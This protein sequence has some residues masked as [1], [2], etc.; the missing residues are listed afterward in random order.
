MGIIDSRGFWQECFLVDL[1]FRATSVL[2]HKW[3]MA[4]SLRQ[5][6]NWFLFR[7]LKK[8]GHKFEI[9][10][11]KHRSF[12]PLFFRTLKGIRFR[13]NFK[14][15]FGMLMAVRMLQIVSVLN[16]NRSKVCHKLA[17]LAAAS[18]DSK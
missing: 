18:H 3:N 14:L 16:D 9:K 15:L 8:S 10:Y 2:K 6:H 13:Q 7:S 1:K 4:S 5:N 17:C 11:L 12:K